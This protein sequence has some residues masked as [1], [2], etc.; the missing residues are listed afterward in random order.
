MRKHVIRWL[1]TGAACGAISSTAWTVARWGTWEPYGPLLVPYD[2]TLLVLAGAVTFAL[3]GA[4][5]ERP[6][7]GPIANALAAAVAQAAPFAAWIA[8]LYDSGG[9]ARF[10]LPCAGVLAAAAAFWLWSAARQRQSRWSLE[11]FCL[12]HALAA[13]ISLLMFSRYKSFALLYPVLLAASFLAGL[14]RPPAGGARG[15]WTPVGLAAMVTVLCAAGPWPWSRQRVDTALHVSPREGHSVI[16]IVLDTLR[17]DH[18]SLYGYARRTTPQLDRWARDALVF[19][20]VTSASSWTLP[21]HASMFTGLYPRSHGAHAFRGDQQVG[22]AHRLNSA[23]VTL[24]EIASAAGVETAAIVANHAYLSRRYQLDQG[25]RTYWVPVPKKGV[26][27]ALCDHLAKRLTPWLYE[28]FSWPYYR[29][30]YVTDNA[31][32]WL[33]AARGRPFFL[34]VNYFDMHLPSA[35]PASAE[36][37][38][39]DEVPGS[40]HRYKFWSVLAGE[41]SLDAAVRRDLV[42]S[43]DRELIHLD[44][45]LGRLFD[46]L[47][48]SG[49]AATTTVIVTSDHGE[50]FGEHG[51]VKHSHHLHEEVIHVPL[52][53]KGSGIRPGHRAKPV[54]NVDIFPTVLELLNIDYRGDS[55]GHSL[56]AADASTV[57]AEWYAAPARLSLAPAMK[58]RFD[59]DLRAIRANG[60]KLFV[61]SRGNVALY[62]LEHDP[63]ESEDLSATNEARR[64][65]LQGQ[66][67]AWLAATPAATAEPV[68]AA[69]L[70][71]EDVRRLRDLGYVD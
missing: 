8:G 2:V 57:V 63:T 6:I 56:F 5:A 18:L 22:N 21:S 23:R 55:Q 43:Y 3:L 35:R 25:F 53:V 34:F 11:W 37:P 64:V 65:E 33:R 24:A 20:D 28:Q 66:L 14:P 68:P 46:Y 16:L 15:R 12:V 69:E 9:G 44:R 60:Y 39:E 71:P 40:V 10:K 67:D 59:R 32:R 19:Y 17:Q 29:D 70:A 4:L 42:N 49:L 51:L 50:Y 54:H 13:S 41:T 48:R 1:V 52:L 47:A 61:D 38:L 7:G 62:D 30:R 36:V 45:Q 31:L 27:F 58:G 26:E